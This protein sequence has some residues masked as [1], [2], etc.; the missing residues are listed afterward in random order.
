[1]NGGA[2]ARATWVILCLPD[3]TLVHPGCTQ[4]GVPEAMSREATPPVRPSMVVESFRALF[5]WLSP[6]VTTTRPSSISGSLCTQP[7]ADQRQV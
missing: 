6:H 4:T 1:V 5:G 7:G 3:G 2:E